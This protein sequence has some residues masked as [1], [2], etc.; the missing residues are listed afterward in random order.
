M[1]FDNF[2]N[3]MVLEKLSSFIILFLKI[4]QIFQ[5]GNSKKVASWVVYIQVCEI[6]A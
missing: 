1:N 3:N 6:K 2:V 5:A 4:S